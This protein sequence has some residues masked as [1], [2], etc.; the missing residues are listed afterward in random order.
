[1]NQYKE[2]L[3]SK[4]DCKQWFQVVQQLSTST[5]SSF[6]S[7]LEVLHYLKNFLNQNS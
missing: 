3:R 1:M 4:G 6:F 2:E 5:Y 7:S